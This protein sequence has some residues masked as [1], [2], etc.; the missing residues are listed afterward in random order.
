MLPLILCSTI[1]IGLIST[2][3]SKSLSYAF[4]STIHLF[5]SPRRHVRHYNH[6]CSL[7]LS[8]H[9][10]GVCTFLLASVMKAAKS[11]YQANTLCGSRTM[12]ELQ[13]KKLHHS[14]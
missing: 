12:C 9:Q 5:R 2:A 3:C 7:Q 4:F 8:P 13:M 6:F 11:R 1:K 10:K 14:S